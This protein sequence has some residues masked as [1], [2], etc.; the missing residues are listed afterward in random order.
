MEGTVPFDSATQCHVVCERA[1]AATH[2]ILS[3]CCGPA[4][5]SHLFFLQS[6]T[7]CLFDFEN[8]HA[9][10]KANL[11]RQPWTR[12]LSFD[13]FVHFIRHGRFVLHF[14]GVLS[15]NKPT[16]SRQ[17]SSQEYANFN[18][19]DALVVGVGVIE[20]ITYSKSMALQVCLLLCIDSLLI[21]FLLSK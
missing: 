14:A 20:D 17:N 10:W 16:F 13:D 6:N 18:K 4:L 19:C 1:S 9:T 7:I 8:G 11:N 15:P 3:H 2:S 5:I 21:N 12:L